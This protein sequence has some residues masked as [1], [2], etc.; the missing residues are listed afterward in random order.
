MNL[1]LEQRLAEGHFLRLVYWDL[2]YLQEKSHG[3]FGKVDS[4]VTT[5]SMK[6]QTY[7]ITAK[8]PSWPLVIA[9][10]PHSRSLSPTP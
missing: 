5:M 9:P 6:I 1:H 4:W 8:L 7:F 2:F 10:L 3:V